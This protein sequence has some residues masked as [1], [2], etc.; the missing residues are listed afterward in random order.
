MCVAM[1]A[2]H[3]NNAGCSLPPPEVTEAGAKALECTLETPGRLFFVKRM[4]V[5]KRDSRTYDIR[6]LVIPADLSRLRGLP[7]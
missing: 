3:F 1:S 5:E 4:F 6:S 7:L 2:I